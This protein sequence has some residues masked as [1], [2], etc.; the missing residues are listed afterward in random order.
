MTYEEKYF[1]WEMISDY[2]F[3]TA[4]DMIYA[5]RWMYVA[6]VCYSAASRLVKGL[7]VYDTHKEAPKSDNLIFLA[8]RLCESEDFMHTPEGARFKKEKSDYFDIMADIT[9]YHISDYPFSYQKV[10]DRFIGRETALSVYESTK[11]LLLWL[12]TFAPST[13]LSKEK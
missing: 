2:D 3:A 8:G 7:I 10:G 12:K 13:F 6:S 11:K 1:Y 9:F 4:Q 5:E